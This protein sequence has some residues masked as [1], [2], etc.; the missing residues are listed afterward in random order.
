VTKE[1]MIAAVHKC[2]SKL[3]R[4][5]RTTDFYKHSGVTVCQVRKN[6]GTFTR[7]LR[8]SGVEQEGPGFA[9]AME[10]LFL[11]WAKVTRKLGKIP[12]KA[13]YAIE[14]R[15]SVRPFTRRFGSWSHVP[16][17][18]KEYATRNR[19]E[20]DWED[21]LKII[22]EHLESAGTSPGI[23]AATLRTKRR[24]DRPIYGRPM[25]GT[26]SFTPTNE[27]GVIFL[28]GAVGDELGFFITRI[29]T[30]FPDLEALREVGPN[31]CQRVH[32]EAEYESRN[33]LTHMHSLDGCDGIVCWIHNWPECPLE[34]IE[35]RSVVEKLARKSG[36]R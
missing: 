13:D 31:Q 25:L 27:Q 5:P 32:L 33:F 9:L 28:F 2:V 26:L 11:D 12:T 3:G 4:T 18:M 6:F 30:E 24:P 14:G 23:S 21:V 19:L 29:Q 8:A 22:R 15:Y 16:H 10:P 35:L 17:G 20:G 36:D 34:V 1:E 7:L